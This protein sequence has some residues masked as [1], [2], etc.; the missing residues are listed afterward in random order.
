MKFSD[1]RYKASLGSLGLVILT[2]V[3]AFEVSTSLA[4]LIAVVFLAALWLVHPLWLGAITVYARVRLACVGL[5]ALATTYYLAPQ[6]LASLINNMVM[7]ANRQW[8]LTLTPIDTSPAPFW[9]FFFVVAGIAVIIRSLPDRPIMPPLSR[10]DGEIDEQ[11]DKDLLAF[12]ELWEHRLTI[13]DRET[14]WSN[15]DFVSLDA[16]VEVHSLDRNQRRVGDIVKTL[17]AEQSD[18]PILILGEPGSGKSVVLR[19]LCR[20]LLKETRATGRLPIYI[21]LKNWTSKLGWTEEQ[22]PT[23][24]ELRDYIHAY[25]HREADDIFAD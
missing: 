21:N 20:E 9:I 18:Q 7:L 3:I 12:A 17:R 14:N 5:L 23:T 6:Y 10:H 1:D 19:R 25:I 22:P 4:I 11:F 8:H 15:R 13:I 24:A 2:I 16:E